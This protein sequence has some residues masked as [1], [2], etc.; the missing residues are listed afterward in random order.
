MWLV[1][2]QL[3]SSISCAL[4]LFIAICCPE[5]EYLHFLVICL[6]LGEV[7]LCLKGLRLSLYVR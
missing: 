3:S 7:H 4:L 2:A 5:G 1:G 6:T